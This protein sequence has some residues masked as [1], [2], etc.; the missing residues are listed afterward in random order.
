M[1]GIVINVTQSS[2]FNH[3]RH[4]RNIYKW[5]RSGKIQHDRHLYK[6]K[7]VISFE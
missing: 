4:I 7:L 3:I 6:T 2:E 5:H 1:Y